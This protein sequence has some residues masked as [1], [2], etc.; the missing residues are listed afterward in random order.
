MLVT[1]HF[2]LLHFPRTGGV[3]MRRACRDHLPPDWLLYERPKHGG[4]ARVPAEYAELPMLCFIRNPW[5]WYVSFFEFTRE[6]WLAKGD[7]AP[8]SK[9]HYWSVFFDQGRNDFRPTVR[10]MCTPPA[11]VGRRWAIAMREWDVD[12]LTATF[13][14]TTGRLPG[15]TPPDSPLRPPFSNGKLATGRYENLRDD[16]LGF[17]DRNEIPAPRDFVEHIRTGAPRHQSRR[18]PYHEYYDDELRDLVGARAHSIVDEF[19]YEF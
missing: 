16:V 14:L 9:G 2:V 13:S 1:K 7:D 18:R 12:Y 3:F 10:A 11:A 4:L 15:E 17:L 5:D 8:T 6:F 19:G